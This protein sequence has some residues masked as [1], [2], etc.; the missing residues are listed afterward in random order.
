MSQITRLTPS[1]GPGSGTVTS[2]SGGNNITITGV[3]TVNPTVNVSGTT[4]HAVQVGNALGA[5]TSIPVGL[6]GQVLTGVTGADPVFAA[7]AS[8]SISITGD[9]G[10][11]LTG[12]AFTFTGGTTGLTFSGA[13]TTETITGTLV[14]ANGGTGRATLTNHGLLV[15]AGTAAITQLADAT[16]GQL[17]IG[18]TG[19]DP[20]LATLTAGTG[21]T[22]TN[23]AGSITISSGSAV[24]ESFPTDTGTATPSAGVLNI[25]GDSHNVTTTGSGNTVTVGLTGITQHS[26]QVGGAA[27]ALTQLGVASNGQLPIGST[28]A[29][30]VLATITAGTGISVS[31]GAGSITI[32]ATGT[33]TL[34]VTSVNHAASPYTVL[35][36][37]EFLAVNVSGGVVSILLPNAPVTGRVYYIKDSTGGAATSNITVTTVGGAVN[38]D[39]ATSFVM[40]TAYESISVIFDGSA[41]EVF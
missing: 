40:N 14:V 8:S 12:N 27:E 6:T 18:S 39:G 3:P 9:S 36:T 19:A 5:L 33:T 21:I 16:N 32:S 4:N 25:F 13:G 38:I 41:Y 1:S 23:G 26:L 20:V 30:P 10:G 7:P 35:S 29:D 17:P 22:I 31:N 37:D 34:T 15:G 2:V 24:S 11:A 28:G